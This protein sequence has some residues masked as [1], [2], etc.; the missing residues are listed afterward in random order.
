MSSASRPRKGHED[1][2]K[3]G[4]ALVKGKCY[5]IKGVSAT[6]SDESSEELL[7]GLL[8]HLRTLKTKQQNQSQP[9]RF[10]RLCLRQRQK[11]EIKLEVEI[12]MESLILAQDERW[13]RA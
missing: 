3:K 6:A 12:S 2:A 8:S 13:R 11:L 7:R 4:V 5:I 1:E 9:S 10:V